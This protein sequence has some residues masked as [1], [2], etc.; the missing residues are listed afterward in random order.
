M[1]KKFLFLLLVM[2]THK[3]AP[4]N[5]PAEGRDDYDAIVDEIKKFYGYE[6][7]RKQFRAFTLS[8]QFNFVQGA[9]REI[10]QKASKMI[11]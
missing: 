6:E 4:D 7:F 8:S 11:C 10:R 2:A 1:N 5:V 3:I 9:I